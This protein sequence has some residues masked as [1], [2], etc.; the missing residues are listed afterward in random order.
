MRSLHLI[1]FKGQLAAIVSCLWNPASDRKC[2]APEFSEMDERFQKC[3][4]KPELSRTDFCRSYCRAVTTGS[5]T[6]G[7]VNISG[8]IS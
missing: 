4:A 1:S 2:F 3:C 5:V 7:C 8:P 6:A